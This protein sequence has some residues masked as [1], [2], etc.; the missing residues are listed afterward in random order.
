MIIILVRNVFAFSFCWI[1]SLTGGGSGF[2]GGK[3]ATLTAQGG[4]VKYL[5]LD[6]C[7]WKAISPQTFDR[8]LGKCRLKLFNIGGWRQVGNKNQGF[9]FFLFFF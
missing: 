7:V 1:Q 6:Y 3:E 2:W 5:M 9:F 4:K 8:L